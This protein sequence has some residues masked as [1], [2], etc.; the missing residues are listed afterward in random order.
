MSGHAGAPIV[1]VTEGK[2]STCPA[3]RAR[4]GPA[5]IDV[6]KL[7]LGNTDGVTNAVAIVDPGS[8]MALCFDCA[9]LVSAAL[10]KAEAL[11]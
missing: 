1:S 6:V 4:K 2:C 9:R 11:S 3:G 5:L 10:S 7:E 8:F